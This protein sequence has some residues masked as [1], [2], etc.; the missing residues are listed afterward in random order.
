[1]KKE[2]AHERHEKPHKE[3]QGHEKLEGSRHDNKAKERHGHDRTG[4]SDKHDEKRHHD[5]FGLGNHHGEQT[6]I[7][8]LHKKG[9]QVSFDD[10]LEELRRSINEE[11]I[12][13]H[14]DLVKYFKE[15]IKESEEKQDN[16]LKK[17]DEAVHK[18]LRKLQEASGIS[19]QGGNC[20]CKKYDLFDK[21]HQ[22]PHQ[23]KI[24]ARSKS[25]MNIEWKPC[26]AR[27]SR[28]ADQDEYA[29]LFNKGTAETKS[30]QGY[31][32]SADLNKPEGMNSFLSMPDLFDHQAATNE[33]TNGLDTENDV[34][35]KKDI[36]IPGNMQKPET[37]SKQKS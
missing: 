3:Y 27:L 6:G 24:A 15:A 2:A 19:G 23:N 31:Q 33:S 11:M 18:Q 1:M 29:W 14:K 5:K 30:K 32:L 13:S 34:A 16:R 37:K 7:K 12:R 20:L 25:E 17:L 21:S 10:K 9:S 8:P 26:P 36:D 28:L 35:D 22:C 4:P